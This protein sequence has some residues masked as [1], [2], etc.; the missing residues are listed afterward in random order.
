M[1][2]MPI[3]M[4]KIKQH[5]HLIVSSFIFVFA[6]LMEGLFILLNDKFQ[7]TLTHIFE[8]SESA[9]S[10]F[11]LYITMLSG[12]FLVCSFCYLLIIVVIY[13]TDDMINKY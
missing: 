13:I 5:R 1:K 4:F 9:T 2:G 7:H 8:L 12:M 3:L 10:A 11:T 6:L